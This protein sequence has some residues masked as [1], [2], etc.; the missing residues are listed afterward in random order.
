MSGHPHLN[1]GD[2]VLIVGL[3]ANPGTI[4]TVTDLC[5]GCPE[6]QLDN[7]TTDS[8]CSDVLDLGNFVTIRL[9]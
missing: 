1:C 6:T 2:Q 7:Y 4:K 3:G 8:R 9:R 5:P